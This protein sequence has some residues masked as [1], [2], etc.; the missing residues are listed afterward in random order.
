MENTGDS[1]IAKNASWSFGIMCEN[2]DNHVSKSVPL[3]REGH[4]LILK[5]SDFFISD[6]ST[7]YEISLLNWR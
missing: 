7:C 3:Y 1:I 2:F 6:D 4:D 5:V